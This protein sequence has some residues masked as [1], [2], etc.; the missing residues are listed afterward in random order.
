MRS[1]PV[2]DRQYALRENEYGNSSDPRATVNFYRAIVGALKA[3]ETGDGAQA[4]EKLREAANSLQQLGAARSAKFEPV[5]GKL[6]KELVE[7]AVKIQ[8]QRTAD[9]RA[10]LA[11]VKQPADLEAVAA[12]I[13][14]WSIQMRNRGGEERE[15]FSQ[16]IQQLN[17]L[18]AAWGSA[19]PAL[20]LQER[21]GGALISGSFAKE[22]T[23][24]R[25]RIE[26]DV[27]ARVLK[28][29]ELNAPPLAEKAPE[30]A[31]DAFCDDLAQRSE[32]R[33]LLQVLQARPQTQFQPY[34]RGVE[35]ETVSALKSFFAA[36]NL[37]LA[38]QWADAAQAYKTVL[39]STGER[40][41]IKSAA[42]RLKVLAKKHPEAV[43]APAR[44]SAP[45]FPRRPA[46][47]PEN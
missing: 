1:V 46:A 5:L 25:S 34:G 36:Q 27:I 29:P 20:L 24:L 41:P 44:E 39:R 32:W 10:R 9:L 13:Q 26:R 42:D 23:T 28:A 30:A 45:P 31:I 35:D 7:K 6:D 18:S 3:V 40:I 2:A 11:A 4:Q 14:T 38:E 47:A 43:A 8:Q 12:E 22:L 21:G 33:R 16:L 19:S 17:L 37:E 15:D